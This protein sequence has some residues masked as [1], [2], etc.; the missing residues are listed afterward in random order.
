MCPQNGGGSPA[1]CPAVRAP[2]LP[3]P[4]LP[5]RR[6]P[7]E[8]VPEDEDQ[9]SAWLHRLYQEKVSAW[10]GPCQL[11]SEGTGVL[12][13]CPVGMGCPIEIGG[14]ELC[15]WTRSRTPAMKDPGAG[16]RLSSRDRA[17][18]S[19]SSRASQ[20]DRA[21]SGGSGQERR[22]WPRRHLS[23]P[24]GASCPVSRAHDLG[25]PGPTVWSPHTTA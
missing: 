24:L 7:L 19:V 8:Q 1:H 21:C 22:C 25:A 15:H 4:P 12:G 3:A 5:C 11:C 9:C 16:P 6:I 17:Q 18:Q 14:T 10:P 23:V 20:R 2:P 13:G